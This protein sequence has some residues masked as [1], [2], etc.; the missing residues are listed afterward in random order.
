VHTPE[1]ETWA[2]KHLQR[3]LVQILPPEQVR[4]QPPQFAML[5]CRSTQPPPHTARPPAQL[6]TQVPPEQTSL[7]LQ[8]LPQAPQLA[9]SL[10]V[11]V[12]SVAHMTSAPGQTQ[13]PLAHAS[14]A[15]QETPQPP[16]LARLVLVSTH[17]APQDV[18]GSVHWA[19]HVPWSQ[20]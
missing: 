18:R 8:V 17:A 11:S 20:T 6:I 1:H 7:T 16:Q 19:A 5:V 14:P 12:H 15:A 13:A 9:E 10:A 2:P 3:P 4:P